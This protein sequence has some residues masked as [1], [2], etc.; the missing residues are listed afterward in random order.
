MVDAVLRGWQAHGDVICFRG[1]AS[2]FPVYLFV[3]PDHVQHI[4]AANGANYAHPDSMRAK[5]GRVVG[6]S[7]VTKEGAVWEE[8]R[9][10][11]RSCSASPSSSSC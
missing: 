9:Q 8:R 1:R 4:L 10:R 6:N 11:A 5:F 3:H 7:L 2:L